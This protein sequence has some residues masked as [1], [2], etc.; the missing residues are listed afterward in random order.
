MT[1]IM[2]PCAFVSERGT[3]A[4]LPVC[5]ESGLSTS[6]AEL[7]RAAGVFQT[8]SHQPTFGQRLEGVSELCC[9]HLSFVRAMCP[10]I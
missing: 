6:A 8:G 1:R 7:S 5:I 9:R 10:L 3:D 4:E 2:M